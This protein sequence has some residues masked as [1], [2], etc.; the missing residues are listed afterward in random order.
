LPAFFNH[1]V[2]IIDDWNSA[3][4]RFAAHLVRD[5][6]RNLHPLPSLS[7]VHRRGAENMQTICKPRAERLIRSDQLNAASSSIVLRLA[8]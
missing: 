8:V 2:K 1:K 7:K 4:L 3:Y 6:D 5:F